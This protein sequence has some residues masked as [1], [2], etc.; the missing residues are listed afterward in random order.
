MLE[1]RKKD[2]VGGLFLF[3]SKLGWILGG[4]V[5]QLA[6]RGE[7]SIGF[8]IKPTAHMLTNIDSSLSTKPSMEDFWNLESTGITDSPLQVMNAC[9][10]EDFS[11]N[12]TFADWRYM[13]TCPWK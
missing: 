11:K 9:A 3:H 1:L 6:E 5:K 2:F 12:V 8:S 4:R 7:E 10:F 13:V